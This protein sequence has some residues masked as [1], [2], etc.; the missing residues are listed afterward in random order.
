MK[1]EIQ[2]GEMPKHIIET[3]LNGDGS[4]NL[5]HNGKNIQRHGASIPQI[6]KIK[7]Y[8]DQIIY[9]DLLK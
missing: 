9:G 7:N 1:I 3:K 2:V 8:T 5:F 4:F 6:E